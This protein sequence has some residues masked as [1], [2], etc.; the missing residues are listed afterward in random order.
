M[1]C[2]VSLVL[3]VALLG[4]AAGCNPKALW[5][6]RPAEV[7]AEKP[8]PAAEALKVRKQKDPPKRKPKADTC[9][10]FGDF[11]MRESLVAGKTEMEQRKYRDEAR[12]AYQQ[13]LKID[14][15]C[16]DAHRG[17]ARVYLA[18]GDRARA[19]GAYRDGLKVFPKDAPLW[20][21]LG[22]AHSRAREWEPAGQALAKAHELDRDNPQYAHALGY[23]FARAGMMEQ[24]L[25]VFRSVVGE[26]RAHYNVGRMMYQMK[27]DGLARLHLRQAVKTEPTLKEAHELL[28]KV[29]GSGP[30]A[31]NP[32]VPVR[33][34]EPQGP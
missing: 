31:G 16:Q 14:P 18:E 4:G 5:S 26:A 3:G 33:H 27:Q 1:D 6:S 23:C 25:T 13:A 12:K 15:K 34:E 9:V 22:M 7:K 2:R 19:V 17:L 30:R 28:A 32:I 11:R 10:K 29:E 21:E 24:S 20:F 8:P